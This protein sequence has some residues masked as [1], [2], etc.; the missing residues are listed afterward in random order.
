[1]TSSLGKRRFYLARAMRGT[2]AEAPAKGGGRAGWSDGER[3]GLRILES[4]SIQ[5]PR[6]TSSADERRSG[7]GGIRGKWHN[8]IMPAL[9]AAPLRKFL[10]INPKQLLGTLT[11]GLAKEGF[12]T[13]VGTTFSWEQEIAELQTALCQMPDRLPAAVQWSVLLEYVLPI[14]GQRLDCVLLADDMIFVIEYKGGSS[15]S[16]RAAL[17][18]AQ[19][20][21]LN[22]VDFHEASRR[23]TAVPVAV[24]AFKTSIAMDFSCEHQGAAVSPAE[25]PD[26]LA[27]SHKIWGA[28]STPIEVNEWNNSRY[29]PVPT[30]IQAASAIYRDHDVK[31]LACSRAGTDNLETTQKAVAALVRDARLRGS[32]KLIVITGV[33]GAGKTLAGLNAVQTLSEEL[34]LEVEQASFLSGNGPLVAV[35]QEALKR[36]IGS[37]KKGVARS[38][39]SRIREIHRFVRDSYGDTRAPADRLIVFDEAQRAWTAAKNLKKFDRDV[40]EP[41]M[42]LEIM[43]RHDGWAVVV[44]LVGGGQEIHGRRGRARGMG[45]RDYEVPCVGCGHISGGSTGRSLGSWFAAFPGRMRGGGED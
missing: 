30:I 27:Q 7:A 15:T 6:L 36:S 20:Y 1:M 13:N 11:S 38:V 31:D 22:L 41:E 14:V 44:A 2:D 12:D 40:S 42:V 8:R 19:E 26:L 18:Q 5:R 16:A 33:P 34:D 4:A 28:K 23:R 10:E 37:R 39:R 32:K 24:G 29:F 25:L 35:I 3:R 9:Y 21:A 43:G 45:R 17:Q